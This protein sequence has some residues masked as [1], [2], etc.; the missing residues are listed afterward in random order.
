MLK[1]LGDR[2][3][4][5]TREPA[6]AVWLT[7][8]ALQWHCHAGSDYW[9]VTDGVQT[10]HDGSAFV[11]PVGGDFTLE[12]TVSGDLTAQFDQVGL[13]LRVDEARW[14]K[15]GV[16]LDD[17]LWLS[18]VHTNDASDWS[19][20]PWEA[21]GATLRMVRE[22]GT[23]KVSIMESNGGWSEYRIACV[24]GNAEVGVYSCGPLGEG[25]AATVTRLTLDVRS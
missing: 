20:E 19:R 15:A 22:A 17:E 10:K 14:L 23:V 16:E 3:W 24:P 6:Q 4:T 7:A 21:P 1:W 25:F 9:R 8:G 13:F 5:W 11:T 18:A 12:A 2:G